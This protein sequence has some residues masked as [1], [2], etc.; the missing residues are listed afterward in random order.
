MAIHKELW[1]NQINENFY[2]NDDFLRYFTDY[3][4]FV[5]ADV[6]HIPV[7]G[8]DPTIDKNK[9]GVYTDDDV[10]PRVDSVTDKTL[11]V[12]TSRPQLLQLDDAIETSYDKMESI[13]QQHRNTIRK[14][15]ALDALFDCSPND[16]Q[17]ATMP[18]ILTTGAAVS[19]G[20]NTRR[21]RLTVADIIAIKERFD[22]LDYPQEGRNL[23]LSPKHFSD[24]LLLD[25]QTFK[26]I[27]DLQNGEPQRFAGFNIFTSSAT[28][29]YK[30]ESG[31]YSKLAKDSA[32][33][34]KADSSF[35]FCTCSAYKADG[36]TAMFHRAN[37][38]LLRGDAL[39]FEK[40]FAAGRVDGR[41]IGVIVS[42]IS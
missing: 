19:T 1:V 5:S 31:V 4:A 8:A 13:I 34:D 36:N 29:K 9:D 32:V 40:R 42:D 25:V 24:L 18:V 11:D 41:G 38:P 3:S 27:T 39:N 33:A 30:Y 12:Y 35:V 16:S 20:T 22:D 28:T 7:I 23:V 26:N 15:V 6:L 21:K 2:P 10:T 14:A 37:D 17:S